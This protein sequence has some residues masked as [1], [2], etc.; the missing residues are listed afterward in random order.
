MQVQA[1][2]RAS[3]GQLAS[4]VPGTAHERFLKPLTPIS[5][6]KGVVTLA[7]PGNFVAEWVKDKYIDRI[8]AA[9]SGE[10]GEPVKVRIVVTPREKPELE[11]V[12]AQVVT[13]ETAEISVQRGSRFKPNPDFTF[14]SFVLGQ[15]N[16]LAAGGAKAVATSPGMKYNPLFIYG[17]SGLGK[18]HLL[19]AIANEI[20]RRDPRFPL[21]YVSG[22]QFMEDFVKA[23]QH[24]RIDEF[25]RRHRSVS[26]WLLDDVQFIMGKEKTQEEVFHTFNE[27]HSDGKQI[28]L[29]GDRP[30]RDLLEMDERL[31]SRLE[32]GLV[33]DV[34]MPDT[35]T[36]C[37][38][39]QNKAQADGVPLEHD[40]AMFLAESVPGNIRILQGALTKLIAESS[41]SDRPLSLELATE[42]VENYY[43]AMLIVKP[44][45]ADIVNVVSKHYRIDV[46]AILGI[47]RKAPIAHA[48]HVSVYLVREITGDSWKHIGTQFGNRDHSSMMH[49]FTKVRNLATHDR[50][51]SNTLSALRR[52]AWPEAP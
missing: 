23:L 15:S 49:A 39:L 35:E 29:C 44:G 43:K 41:F 42:L 34:Q 6:D 28:V 17:P 31:R 33:A 21:V 1:V 4:T 11:A 12:E 3:L 40:V 5:A 48:R 32:C 20:L 2:W 9:L 22:Q 8:E 7:A 45:F 36:R 38:I 19:H 27:L 13:A 10:I 37:A 14:D 46:E 25:R 50:D 24:N 52:Q 30:P 18:T 16:R 51:F 47:S 26:V